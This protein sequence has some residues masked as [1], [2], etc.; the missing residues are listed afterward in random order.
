MIRTTLAAVLLLAVLVPDVQAQRHARAPVA[1]PAVAPV[2]FGPGEKVVY[3]VTYGILGKRGNAWSEV[4]GID[5]VRGSPSYHLSFRLQGGALGFSINDHQE[6]WLDVARLFSHR[7]KQD[8]DQPRYERLRTLDFYPAER[9]WRR[10][11]KEESGPLATDI[12][13]DDVS[14]LYWARTLPLEVGET[15]T[16]N[17]YYKDEGNP[18]RVQVLRRERVTVPAGTFNTIVVR[19]LIRTSGMFSEGGQAEVY[20]TD[21]DSRLIVLVKTSMVIGR[22]QMQLESYTPGQLLGAGSSTGTG[23]Q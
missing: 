1:P 19:P 2:P 7:F 15:Y 12:P 9:L 8:L 4:V 6:S 23:R 17:R 18:V 21:D 10:V 22:M 3:R 20:F 11:E 14:F 16:F 13:L 5:T